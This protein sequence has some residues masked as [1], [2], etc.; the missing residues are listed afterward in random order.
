MSLWAPTSSHSHLVWCRWREG[1]E[2]RTLPE[3][4]L[5]EGGAEVGAF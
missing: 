2:A 4:V 1:G 3:M 5:E